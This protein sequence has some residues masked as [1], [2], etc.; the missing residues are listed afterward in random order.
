MR[1]EVHGLC[2]LTN[3]HRYR[4]S[5]LLVAVIVAVCCD[6]PIAVLGGNNPISD[7][8]SVIAV[9]V[10]DWRLGSD[11]ASKLIVAIWGDGQVVWSEKRELGGPPYRCAVIEKAR[12]SELLS[13][14]SDAGYCV[15]AEVNKPMCGPDEQFS[16][17]F[18]KREEKLLKMQSSHEIR[19]ALHRIAVRDGATP[20][21]RQLR[22]LDVLSQ[23]SRE[24]LFYRV[25]WKD[26]RSIIQE[27]VPMVGE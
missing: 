17:I 25:A 3:E 26:V 14:I 19:D 9:Y 2:V 5:A 7:G 27:L 10:E 18:V 22:W 13:T 8:N 1:I 20:P 21:A 15:N 4:A 16:V 24:E 23:M 11:G 6:P 12:M